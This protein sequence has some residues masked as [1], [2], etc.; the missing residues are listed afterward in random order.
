MGDIPTKRRKDL[1]RF[2][3]EE[4]SRG[5]KARLPDEEAIEQRN[6]LKLDMRE[7]LKVGDRATF[8]RILTEDYGLQLGSERYNL[9][10]QAWNEYHRG[11][12]T[13]R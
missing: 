4:Q 10:L 3:R 13:S 9:A 12:R 1:Q 11:R 2:I 8:L 6:L 5:T 7:L